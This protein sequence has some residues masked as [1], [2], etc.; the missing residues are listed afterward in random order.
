MSLSGEKTPLGFPKDKKEEYFGNDRRQQAYLWQD[1]AIL[2]KEMKGDKLRSTKTPSKGK[3]WR[4]SGMRPRVKPRVPTQGCDIKGGLWYPGY[5]GCLWQ[6]RHNN[7][8]EKERL[9]MKVNMRK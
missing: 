9:K 4:K 2:E 1:G 3:G 8:Q 5:K 6:P 7:S